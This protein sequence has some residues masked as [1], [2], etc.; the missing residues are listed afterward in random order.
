[1]ELEQAK[2]FIKKHI[3]GHVNFVARSREGWDYYRN[4]NSI[5]R[6]T[7]MDDMRKK[8]AQEINPLRNSDFRISHNWHQLLVNQKAAYLF[9]YAPGFDTGNHSLN[10][11]INDILGEDFAK[12]AKDL[13]ISA[14]NV[15]VAWLHCWVDDNNLFRYAEVPAYQVVPVYS[16]KL[17]SKLETVLRSYIIRDDNAEEITRYEVWTDKEV[18]FF[19]RKGKNDIVMSFLEGYETNTM[20][21]DMGYVPF[22]PFYNNS[23][24]SGDLP[25][26]KDLIDQYDLVVSGFANDLADVQEVI[27]IL[28]NYGGEDLNAFLTDLKRYKAIKVENDGTASGGGVEAMQIEIPVEARVKFLDILKKQIFISG[29][30]VDPD[31]QNFGNSSGVALKYLYS[32]LEIKAGLLETEFRS[33]FNQLLRLI[34]HHLNV[35]E[36]TPVQQIYIRNA[37]VNDQETA[38]I[39]AQSVGIISEKTIL[40]NH[41]WVEDA[42]QEAEQLAKEGQEESEEYGDKIGEA[43]G[44]EE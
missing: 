7:Y 10:M 1:M 13:C 12:V 26:I 23:L 33:G 18:S 39:A 24:K 40:Q 36:D 32:L 20:T 15:G 2:K 19:E 30:G 25:M 5:K 4:S 17:D 38:G 16:D 42:E 9:T 34:F 21:H 11:R 6:N 27:F 22:I 8:A 41:P 29:Q 44:Q 28:R 35:A 43:H 31:P 37:I 14:S 3:E